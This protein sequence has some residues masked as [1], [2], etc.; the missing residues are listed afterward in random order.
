MSV[1][2]TLVVALVGW[3]AARAQYAAN[4]EMKACN[5]RD[6]AWRREYDH[7][8]GMI[9]AG[10]R[11][12]YPDAGAFPLGRP[13]AAARGRANAWDDGTIWF[14]A[15]GEGGGDV[16]HN[17][18]GNVAEYVID[19]PVT[20]PPSGTGAGVKQFL[21]NDAVKVGVIGG[22]AL[23]DPAMAVDKV[24]WVNLMDAGDGYSD[25]GFRL[26]F[27][28]GSGAASEVGAEKRPLAERLSRILDPLPV[29]PK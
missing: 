26:A 13:D 14:R 22:S 11:L 12:Q 5:L 10:K 8:K 19:A 18:V 6:E 20:D 15:V 3:A 1:R 23:G 29:L 4:V 9:A 16:V 21:E 2:Q 7:V 25:V 28:V 27:S 24:Q 17:L